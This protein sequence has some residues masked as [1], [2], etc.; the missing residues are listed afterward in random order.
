MS[1]QY[2]H[3]TPV[4]F[5]RINH[6]TATPSNPPRVIIV[7]IDGTMANNGHRQHL[8]DGPKKHWA[9]FFRAADKDVVFEEVKYLV[10]LA[11][12]NDPQV[13]VI[14]CTG[15]PSQYAS[16]TVKW[17][18][19]NQ[20]PFDGLIMRRQGDGRPDAEVKLQ[21]LNMI[22]ARGFKPFLSID[23]RPEVVDMWRRMGIPTLQCDASAWMKR[24]QVQHP[25]E[26]LEQALA[27]I[28]Q[29]DMTIRALRDELERRDDE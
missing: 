4:V 9:Q 11:Y 16:L 15:R 17:L 29:R 28:E 7:D 18:D 13:I 21:M 27:I 20:I 2:S 25:P 23:D 19:D 6:L 5:G 24:A 26:T 14:F 8:M 10:R 12:Y 1:N 22:T 3:K